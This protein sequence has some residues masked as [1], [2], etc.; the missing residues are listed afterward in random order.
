MSSQHTEVGGFE[1]FEALLR[2]TV[3]GVPLML[4]LS[5]CSYDEYSAEAIEARVVDA[6]SGAPL[7]GVNVIAAWQLKGGLEG[8]NIEG[9]LEVLEAV[10]DTNGVFRIPAWGPKVKGQHGEFAETAPRLMLFKPGYRYRS[11]ANVRPPREGHVLQSDWN[12]KTI[13]MQRFIG[14]PLEYKEELHRLPIDLD[15]LHRYV[16]D[17]WP[18]IPRFLCAAAR[19]ER[20]LAAQ[21]APHALPSYKELARDKGPSCESQAATVQEHRK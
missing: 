19:F 20:D 17:Y 10:T 15:N 13:P 3:I 8:G 16:G 12:G 1:R 5:G 7:E 9:Y 14:S 18:H 2:V 11:V 4:T 21:G 6:N